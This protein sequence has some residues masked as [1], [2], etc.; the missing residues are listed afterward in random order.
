MASDNP[1]CN[2]TFVRFLNAVLAGVIA[3]II[4]Y[5][6]GRTVEEYYETLRSRYLSVNTT[7]NNASAT[8]GDDIRA[9]NDPENTF[10]LPFYNA[11]IT[12]LNHAISDMDRDIKMGA[13]Y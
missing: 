7:K 13:A 6:I 3:A 9:L 5:T 10:Y 11:P 12:S 8:G 1:E 2:F 4:A